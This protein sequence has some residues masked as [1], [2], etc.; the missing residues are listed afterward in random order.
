MHKP[1]GQDARIESG[2]PALQQVSE[3]SA[4]AQSQ[5]RNRYREKGEVIK[6]HDR[7]QS[8]ERQFQQEGGETRQPQPGQQSSFRYFR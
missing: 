5:Q 1:R 2:E 3:N 8:R 7:K 4:R 6:Q